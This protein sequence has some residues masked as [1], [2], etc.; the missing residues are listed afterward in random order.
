MAIFPELT[1]ALNQK[2]KNRCN[3]YGD[4][5]RGISKNIMKGW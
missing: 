4:C 1:K 2:V 5:N 3:N